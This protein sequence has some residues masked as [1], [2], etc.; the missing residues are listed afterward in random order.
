MTA[1][2]AVQVPDRRCIRSDSGRRD[3]RADP[4]ALGH[5]NI[6]V[7]EPVCRHAFKMDAPGCDCAQGH[8]GRELSEQPSA[9]PCHT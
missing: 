1:Q 7:T 2:T 5:K 4:R 8:R 3:H 9:I 6:H